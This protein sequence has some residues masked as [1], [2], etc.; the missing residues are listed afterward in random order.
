MKRK[1]IVFSVLIALAY[2]MVYGQDTISSGEKEE[3]EVKGFN[4]VPLPVIGYNVDIGFQYGLIVNFFNYGDGSLYPDYKYSLYTEFS[5]T[6]KG[7]GVN[8]LF[9]DSKY[10]IP[11]N[12][13][14]TA[15]L[16]YLTELTLNFYGF[17]GY[18]AVYHT[19]FIDEGSEEYQSR[20]FYNQER[21]FLRFTSDLQGN[22]GI[23]NMKWLGGIGYFN[24]KMGG[25]DTERLNK[26]KS[27]TKRLPDTTLLI[28]KYQEWGIIGEQEAQ[29]GIIPS[30]KTGLIYDSRDNEPNPMKGIWTEALLFYVPKIAGNTDFSYAKLAITH[31]QYF[32]LIPQNLNLVYRLGYQGNI[33]GKS[34]YFMQPY[35]IT[36]FA[37]V[38]TTDG[39]GGAKSLRGILRNRVVGDAIAFAN[40]EARY[41]FRHAT[42]FRS[43]IYWSINLFADAGRVV[44]KMELPA[45]LDSKLGPDD[46]FSDFFDPGT[47]KIHLTAGGGL[48][49]VFDQNTVIN[50]E[51]GRAFDQRDGNG[52]LYIG[53]GFLF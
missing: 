45:D 24:I 32:T 22:I 44:K 16:S 50:F 52:G 34:P 31:R 28:D 49:L 19:E 7:S 14:I 23:K 25:V 12:I 10:L 39:L 6:T 30:I 5:R 26:G 36:S 13:R 29:G 33:A 2:S 46:V 15:D 20:V 17:N 47:E 27:E 1:L 21:K 3:K 43:N 8:Q 41:K 48:Q 38:T 53:I 40:I 9:F 11:G 51:Y 37:K 4:F 42:L 18:D 35:M